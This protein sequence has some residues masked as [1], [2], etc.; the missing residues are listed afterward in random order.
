MLIIMYILN[1]LYMFFFMSK[2]YEL[3]KSNHIQALVFFLFVQII[4]Y[5]IEYHINIHPQNILFSMILDFIFILVVFKDSFLKKLT[6]FS[7]LY[8]TIIFTKFIL[9]ICLE[10]PHLIYPH[11]EANFNEHFITIILTQLFEYFQLW[12]LLKFYKSHE[13][14]KLS[15]ITFFPII[16]LVS[17]VYWNHD[18]WFTLSKQPILLTYVFIMTLI[19][20]I[21]FFVQSILIK[22]YEIKK[23]LEFQ[24][25]INKYNKIQ[26]ETLK[27]NHQN[28]FDFLHNLLHNISSLSN[29]IEKN[30]IKSAKLD[31]NK[32]EEMAY[33]AFNRFYSNNQAMSLVLLN[34]QSIFVE[35]NIKTSFIL[36]NDLLNDFPLYQQ[37]DL[38]TKWIHF[39]LRNVM[40]N[41]IIILHSKKSNEQELIEFQFKTQNTNILD[42]FDHVVQSIHLNKPISTDSKY[43][44]NIFKCIY[45]IHTQ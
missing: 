31:I 1:G 25:E 26:L 19:I 15:Y 39:S 8:F 27:K 41:E 29:N 32:I 23:D 36:D 18:Y 38:Y 28:N 40:P 45:I 3:R 35:K 21:C 30:N 14:S 34:H 22:N 17:T 5:Y 6:C 9:T 7:L 42:E 10:M 44:N 37:I 2:F 33:N 12:L 4:E 24:T 13:F 16:L 43:Q 11:S 20:F